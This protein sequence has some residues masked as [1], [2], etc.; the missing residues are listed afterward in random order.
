[1]RKRRELLDKADILLK[2]ANDDA[3]LR[4]AEI[5]EIA[6]WR[7]SFEIEIDKRDELVKLRQLLEII[8]SEGS[9]H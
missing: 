4:P 3:T 1:M 6:R 8:K 2:A 5:L 9:F 7:L